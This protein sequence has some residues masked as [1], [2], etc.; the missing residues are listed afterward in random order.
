MWFICIVSIS[1]LPSVTGEKVGKLGK[2]V[3]TSI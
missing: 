1:E 3:P 2:D